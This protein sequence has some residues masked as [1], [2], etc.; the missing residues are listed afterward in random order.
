MGDEP[1]RHRPRAL[2]QFFVYVDGK[3]WKPDPPPKRPRRPAVSRRIVETLRALAT[4]GSHQRRRAL[5][6]FTLDEIHRAQDYLDGMI[7]WLDGRKGAK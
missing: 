7:A 2:P 6:Q 3:P 4:P 1:S 5:E